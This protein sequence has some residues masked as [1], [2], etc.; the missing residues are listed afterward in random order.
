LP[1]LASVTP[2]DGLV[3]RLK[4]VD[5]AIEV[6]PFDEVRSDDLVGIS[7]HTFNAIHGYKLAHEA[8][9]RDAT[10]VFG[11]HTRPSFPKRR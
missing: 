6:F 7:I 8:R 9:R 10:V 11:V 2:N 1:V 3:K 4:A 5:Q